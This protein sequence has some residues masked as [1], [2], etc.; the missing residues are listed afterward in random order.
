MKLYSLIIILTWIGLQVPMLYYQSLALVQTVRALRLIEGVAAR[1]VGREKLRAQWY[2]LVVIVSYILLGLLL[3]LPLP[4]GIQHSP[5]TAV[6]LLLGEVVLLRNTRG[7]VVLMRRL[8][9]LVPEVGGPP[10]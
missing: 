2:R 7:D 5:V 6:I 3:L 1:E 9:L 8:A 10:A 4:A